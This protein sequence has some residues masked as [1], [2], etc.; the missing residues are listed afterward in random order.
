MDI[1]KVENDVDTLSEEDYTGMKTD[2]VSVP[3]AV[4]MAEADSEVSIV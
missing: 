3:S 2:D 4:P 1:I